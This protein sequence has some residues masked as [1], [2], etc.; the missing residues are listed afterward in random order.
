VSDPRHGE[1]SMYRGSDTKLWIRW[2]R[3]CLKRKVPEDIAII[4]IDGIQLTQ[5]VEPE[6]TTIQQPIYEIGVKATT[7]LIDLIENKSTELMK[8]V[9]DVQ[10]VKR[11]LTVGFRGNRE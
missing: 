3:R 8:M 2:K 1:V 4:G 5:M 9:L 11:G 6:I 10:L 7:N